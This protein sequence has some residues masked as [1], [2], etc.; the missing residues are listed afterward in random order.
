[1]HT[2]RT[3][4][5]QLSVAYDILASPYRRE[6]LRSLLA[7]EGNVASIE[8]LIDELIDHDETAD[9][10][11]QIAIDLHHRTLPKL[12]EAGFIEY[13]PRTLTARVRDHSAAEYAL[14]T[15]VGAT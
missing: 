1:M 9:D 12:A 11:D 3:D 2:R 7:S 15:S 6:S 8:D 4:T 5:D 10:R 13:D 14:A